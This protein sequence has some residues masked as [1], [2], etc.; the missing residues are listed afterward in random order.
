M[1]SYKPFTAASGEFKKEHL[2]LAGPLEET[3]APEEFKQLINRQPPDY[4]VLNRQ[5]TNY[6]I[7]ENRENECKAFKKLGRRKYLQ[8]LNA[9]FYKLAKG[10]VA[11]LNENLSKIEKSQPEY[12][13][14]EDKISEREKDV[15][16]LAKWFLDE[17]YQIPDLMKDNSLSKSTQNSDSNAREDLVKS[18]HQEK[19]NSLVPSYIL[20][21][22]IN[23]RQKLAQDNPE[24]RTI[25]KKKKT[26]KTRITKLEK[27]F[28]KLSIPED[29]Q[30]K[31]IIEHSDHG[32]VNCNR[33]ATTI[34]REYSIP[35]TN[36]AVK[37]Y[38]ETKGFK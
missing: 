12:Y 3:M 38:V 29:E 36:K 13:A 6:P 16:A 23:E 37:T 33:L 28:N 32:K 17:G 20:F 11:E 10:E 7:T 24:N 26:R 5:D 34:K 19:A 4:L 1:K 14:V 27:E 9:G 18:I 31:L 21:S 30:N 15:E 25:S 8:Q 35:I 2:A 22:E